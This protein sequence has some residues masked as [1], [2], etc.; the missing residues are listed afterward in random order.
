MFAHAAFYLVPLVAFGADPSAPPKPK[1]TP[2]QGIW[3]LVSSQREER[4]RLYPEPQPRWVIKGDKVFYGGE[5]LAGLTID[6]NATPPCIDLAFHRPAVTYEGIF[7]VDGKTLT[8][9]LNK[10]TVGAKERPQ[11]FVTKEKPDW[12]L[13][14]FEREEPREGVEME[15]VIAYIGM[16][17]RVDKGKGLFVG[18]MEEGSNAEK[19]GFRT[20]DQILKIGGAA[21]KEDILAAINAIARSKPGT[22][23]TLTIKRDDVERDIKVKVGVLPFRIN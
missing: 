20:G 17:F 22:E 9:C 1:A 14:V 19:A 12:R 4:V 10:S 5:E 23:I 21:V 15:G 3:K 18:A 13:L 2:L 6:T 8:I 7:S 11:E 16:R